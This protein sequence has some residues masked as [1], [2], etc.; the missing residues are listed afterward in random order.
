[1]TGWPAE[2]ATSTKVND[3]TINAES[4]GTTFS[5]E[6]TQVNAFKNANTTVTLGKFVSALLSAGSIDLTTT[7]IKQLRGTRTTP[8]V[9]WLGST[10]IVVK[11]KKEQQNNKGE[12][13]RVVQITGINASTNC[14]YNWVD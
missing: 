3:V 11:A 9:N 14:S 5:I 7:N 2:V 6:Q 10:P 8:A 12:V 13:T 1:M 4:D